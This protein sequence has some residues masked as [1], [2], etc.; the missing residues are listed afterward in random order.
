MES[1]IVLPGG[2]VNNGKFVNKITIRETTGYE[3]DILSDSRKTDAKTLTVSPSNRITTILSRCTVAIDDLVC[4]KNR[5]GETADELYFTKFWSNA[6]AGDRGFAVIALRSLSLGSEYYFDE[7]CPVCKKETKNLKADLAT[8]GVNQYFKGIDDREERLQQL[9]YKDKLPSGKVIQWKLMR[10]P[11]EAVLG[12]L[13]QS[14]DFASELMALRMIAIDGV[15]AST[16]D[17]KKLSSRDR[18]FFR[19][20][21]VDKAEGGIDME[22][23]FSCVHCSVEIKHQ[24]NIGHP[25]FFFPS[26][27]S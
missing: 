10:A 24:L 15:P 7:I 22:I 11:E 3:E 6:L 9:S 16:K 2:F 17:L 13:R 14:A 23:D 27:T 18:T 5:D 12:G 1:N 4:E 21:I 20:Q 8:L 19:S 25:S 26:V